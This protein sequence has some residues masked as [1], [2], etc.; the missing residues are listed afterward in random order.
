MSFLTP[1]RLYPLGFFNPKDRI[2][3]Q[4]WG[5]QPDQ[6][7]LNLS[8]REPFPYMFGFCNSDPMTI[9]GVLSLFP[10][11]LNNAM[12]LLCFVC[13]HIPNRSEVP[14]EKVPGLGQRRGVSTPPP[15]QPPKRLHIP[16]GH[17]LAATDARGQVPC[18]GTK[19]VPCPWY[20]S[21]K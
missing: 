16:Q 19:A 2:P 10:L 3:C 13:L 6:L 21:V 12:S 4:G 8:Y 7:I 1:K 14:E 5:Q 18:I 15:P 17:I 11:D 20:D 9:L